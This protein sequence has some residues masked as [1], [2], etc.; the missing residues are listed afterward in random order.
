VNVLGIDTSIT[1]TGLASVDLVDK[2]WS[3]IVSIRSKAPAT[4]KKPRGKGNLPPTL[5]QRHER[6]AKLAND[7]VSWPEVR[8]T[9]AVIEGPAYSSGVGSMHDRSGLWWMVVQRLLFMEIPV[10][11]VTPAKRAKYATGKGTVDKDVVM[12][13]VVRRYLD[14]EVTNNNEADALI[15]AMMG[16]RLL[17]CPLDDPP[18]K[19]LEAMA[20]IELPP[21]LEKLSR[22][23]AAADPAPF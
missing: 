12:A 14:Y 7:I 11:E 4:P 16:A 6:L 9:L 17:G 1:C 23:F 5:D 2:G 13:A 20:G 21:S 3:A 19:N 22:E 10:V 8:P 15:L 18:Q